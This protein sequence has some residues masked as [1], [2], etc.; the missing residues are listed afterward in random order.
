M[1]FGIEIVAVLALIAVPKDKPIVSLS[2]RLLL[3]LIYFF[4]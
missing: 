3:I 4:L 1:P 2:H